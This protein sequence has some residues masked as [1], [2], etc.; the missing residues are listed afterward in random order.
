M[1]EIDLLKQLRHPHVLS[2][3]AAFESPTELVGVCVCEVQRN[4]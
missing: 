4:E 2:Y 1:Y 3:V